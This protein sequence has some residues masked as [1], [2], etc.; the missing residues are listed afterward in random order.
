MNRLSSLATLHGDSILHKQLAVLFVLIACD[1][2][3]RISLRLLFGAVDEI[4][5]NLAGAAPSISVVFI[6]GA[7]RVNRPV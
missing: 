4:N 3:K 1:R 5:K 7:G 6:A 2:K